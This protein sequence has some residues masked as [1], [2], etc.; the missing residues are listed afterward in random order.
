MSGT[1]TVGQLRAMLA[2]VD[3]DTLVVMDDGEGWYL[4]VGDVN[5]PDGDQWHC[6]TFHRGPAWDA[7]QL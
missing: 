1:L 6:L 4:N 3:D 2:N 5:T 7:R